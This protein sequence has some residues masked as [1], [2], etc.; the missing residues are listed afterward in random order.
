V[1]KD[2]LLKYAEEGVRK[3]LREIQDEVHILAKDFPHLV[4]NQDGSMPSFIPIEKKKTA[5]GPVRGSRH[6]RGQQSV[7]AVIA[8]LKANPDATTLE[9]GKAVGLR[10]SAYLR[11]LLGDVAK[12]ARGP[13]RGKLITWALKASRNGHPP[14]KA[15][16]RVASSALIR[17]MLIAN[18]KTTVFDVKRALKISKSSALKLLNAVATSERHGAYPATWHLKEGTS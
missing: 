11:Q 10:P 4:L 13:G 8:F 9:V 7:D 18:P 1:R 16:A 12:P 15:P 3:R 17:D 2:E 5:P 14:S 6:E